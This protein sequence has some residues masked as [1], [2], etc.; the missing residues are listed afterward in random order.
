M[1]RGMARSILKGIPERIPRGIPKRIHGR[2]STGI[3]KGTLICIPGSS[4]KG[5]AARGILRG[6]PPGVMPKGITARESPKSILMGIPWGIINYRR[7]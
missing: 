7:S 2:M 3:H 5:I 4:L 6:I 1:P